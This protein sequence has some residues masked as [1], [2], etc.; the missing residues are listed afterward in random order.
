MSKDIYQS[1]TYEHKNGLKYHVCWYQDYDSQSPLEWS[2]C[3]GV[4]E[5][6]DWNPTN[7]EQLEQHIADCEPEVEEVARL[8]LMRQLCRPSNYYDTGLY[9][10]VLTSLHNAKTEW[11]CKTHEDCVAAVERDFAY[12]KG[13]YDN[14]WFWLTIGVAPI[15]EDG[16]PIEDDREYC[17]GYESTILNNDDDNKA[18]RIEVIENQIAEVEWTRRKSIHKNQLELAL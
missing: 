18:W 11:G 16:E 1:E 9:Y 6:M 10:D 17:G 7:A 4:T 3:H 5:R 2:D 12:L 13:W 15:D 8:T 14:D